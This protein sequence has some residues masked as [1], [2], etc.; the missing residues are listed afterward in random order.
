M[1]CILNCCDYFPVVNAPDL[2]SSKQLDHLCPGS[3]NKIK[4]H[5]FQNISKCSNHGLRSFKYKNIFELF[6]LTQDKDK[7]GKVMEKKSF[8]LHK[9]VIYVIHNRFYITTINIVIVS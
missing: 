5:T 4:S 3:L 6:Y 8:V 2:E 1:N 7:R 9:R